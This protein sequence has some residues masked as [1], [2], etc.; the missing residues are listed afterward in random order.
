MS[1]FDNQLKEARQ[2]PV[3]GG[4]LH[5]DHLEDLR[6][7]GLTDETIEAAG[8][9]TVSPEAGEAYLG[10]W[11]GSECLVIEYPGAE[12]YYRL[13]PLRPFRDSQGNERKYLAK[14][15]GGNRLYF[16]PNLPSGKGIITDTSLP[17]IITEGE[18]KALK[19]CQEGFATVGIAGVWC[20]RTAADGGDGATEMLPE[21]KG[22]Q[23]QGRDLYLA[24]DSDAAHN[25]DVQNAQRALATELRQLGARVLIVRLPS[26]STE[27]VGLDDLLVSQGTGAFDALIREAKPSEDTYFDGKSFVPLRLAR[28]LQA[29]EHYIYGVDPEKEGGQLYVYR[30]G[31]YRPAGQVTRE[32][33][34]LLGEATRSTRIQEAVKALEHEVARPNRDFNPDP[35]IINVRNGLLNP[36]TGELTSHTPDYLSTIQLPVEWNPEARSDV[37]DGF[38]ESV[39]GGWEEIVCELTGYLLIPMNVV[40]KLFVLYGPTH[41]GKT[42][43]LNLLTAL[44]GS[45]QCVSISPLQISDRFMPAELEDRLVNIFDD[46]PA[47][48]IEDP[49][50]LKIITGGAREITV[51]RKYQD[52]YRVRNL[53]RMV[54]SANK[55]PASADKNEAWYTRMCIIPFEHQISPED[56]D[57][58]MRETFGKDRQIR[59]AMLVKAVEGLRR[60]K[61]RNWVLEGSA[62]HL[63]EYKRFNDPVRS[64]IDECCEVGDDLQVRRTTLKT[65]YRSY[66]LREGLSR[67]SSAH[68]FYERIRTDGRFTEKKINGERR[69]DGLKLKEGVDSCRLSG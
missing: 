19:A 42:T 15:G 13:K 47:G 53:C 7:S 8:L 14:K 49:S 10:Y 56:Q 1:L 57:P 39:C 64:F 22:I 66:C 69:F 28:E 52:P 21:L 4:R 51:E 37:L 6:D 32:A 9:A 25:L 2:K 62:E 44:V 65:A 61:D 35:E 3:H 17:L 24:F 5:D 59:Q 31:V 46:S 20:W 41:T 30:D 34:E 40:K 36:F 54:F 12:S 33:H 29:R 58:S 50:A 23:W 63:E 27:K 18:K 38:L 43:Y 11:P 26:E 16:P 48:R 68:K 55:L 45:R 67:L 60:L